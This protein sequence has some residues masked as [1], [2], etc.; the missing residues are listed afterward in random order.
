MTK[1][2]MIAE[3][4][5]ILQGNSFADALLVSD[6]NE[7]LLDVAEH[8]RLPALQSS[9]T[10]DT[11]T[12][13]SQVAMPATY[14]RDLYM[15]RQPSVD[16]D[17]IE[18]L[19]NKTS[20]E[21][22]RNERTDTAYVRWCCEEN[23]LFHYLPVPA[24]AKRLTLFFYKKP[25]SLVSVDAAHNVI[26]ANLHHQVLVCAVAA[27]RWALWEDGIDGQKVN[28]AYYQQENMKGLA[29]LAARYPDTPKKPFRPVRKP[30]FF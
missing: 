20:L 18:I 14:H 22:F 6:L 15:V 23:D 17:R 9:D 1:T 21:N 28:T 7:A 30:V 10:V 27:K 19:L 5:R 29:K 16:Y 24:S 12:N 3:L 4:G 26:P 25:S 13:A 2:E 11:L 8:F